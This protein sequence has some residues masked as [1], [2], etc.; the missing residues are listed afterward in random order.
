MEPVFIIGSFLAGIALGSV[1]VW[2]FMRDKIKFARQHAE[3]KS[4]SERAALIERLQSKDD[5]IQELKETLFGKSEVIDNLQK[6][7][8]ALKTSASG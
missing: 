7:I 5:Q 3:M 1:G 2:F 6:E 8:M 4:E